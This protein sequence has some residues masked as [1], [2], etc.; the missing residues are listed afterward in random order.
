MV[1]LTFGTKEFFPIK[2][3]DALDGLQTLDGLGLTHDL[4]AV[5]NDEVETLVYAGQTTL[6]DGMVALPLIDT[7]TPLDEGVYHCY[8]KFS[9]APEMPRLGPFPFR[10]D[11]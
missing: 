7:T 8:I 1:T 5:D 6:N 3:L 2:V 4:Y 10:V 11:D 9:N